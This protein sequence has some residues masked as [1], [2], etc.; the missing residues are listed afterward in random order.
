[1][2]SF[3]SHTEQI[4]TVSLHIL[5]KYPQFHYTYWENTLS[6]ITHTEKIPTVSL[7]ILSKYSQFHCTYWAN[8]RSFIT[9]TEKIPTVSLHILSKYPQFHYTHVLSTYPQLHDTA[10]KH[11]EYTI[12]Y[13]FTSFSV[14]GESTQF[15]TLYLVKADS[16]MQRFQRSRTM[17]FPL[18]KLHSFILWTQKVRPNYSETRQLQIFFNSLMQFHWDVA[19]KPEFWWTTGHNTN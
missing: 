10:S 13:I 16:F 19:H 8:T 14:L 2:H 17:S 11:Y 18:F 9:H 1:M 5:S 3:F 6:F 4:P 12:C 15:D 7:Y